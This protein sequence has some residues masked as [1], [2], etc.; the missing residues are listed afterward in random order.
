MDARLKFGPLICPK[1]KNSQVNNLLWRDC[2]V[3]D[4]IARLEKYGHTDNRYL[5]YGYS[6]GLEDVMKV[7]QLIWSI[8]RHCRPFRDRFELNDN[9]IDIDEI[10]ALQQHPDRW[11]VNFSLPLEK[12]IG[13]K[14]HSGLK[15]QFL[16]L[17]IPFALSEDHVGH[18]VISALRLAGKESPLA[19][20][21]ELLQEPRASRE[22]RDQAAPMLQWT[23]DNIRLGRDVEKEIKDAL[24]AYR[25]SS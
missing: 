13:G 16:Q 2:S 5:T 7:D 3:E 20:D 15:N 1:I 24:A 12:L 19:R 23:L 6:V 4:F 9:L 22:T 14:A 25:A 8:R 17:N 10:D 21:F 18:H 11:V